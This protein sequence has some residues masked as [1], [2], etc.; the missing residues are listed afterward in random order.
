MPPQVTDRP[1]LSQ[2]SKAQ[3]RLGIKEEGFGLTSQKIVVPTA[4]LEEIF[5][6]WLFPFLAVLYCESC[7]KNHGSV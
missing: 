5:Q 1:N 6:E 3:L 2:A 7:N 4:L